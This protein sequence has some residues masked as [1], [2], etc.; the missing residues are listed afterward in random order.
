MYVT[1][2]RKFITMTSDQFTTR[3]DMPLFIAVYELKKD[4]YSE[5]VYYGVISSRDYPQPVQTPAF[6]TFVVSGMPLDVFVTYSIISSDTEFEDG[7]LVKVS[8]SG[9]YLHFD[10]SASSSASLKYSGG[11]LSIVAESATSNKQ[12]PIFLLRYEG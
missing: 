11:K 5:R 6:Y 3:N 7:Q 4:E 2:F 8:S 10:S 12:H 1:K 9:R